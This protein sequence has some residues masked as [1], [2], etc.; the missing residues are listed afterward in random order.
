M[1]PRKR[2]MTPMRLPVRDDI[3]AAM[4]SAESSPELASYFLDRIRLKFGILASKTTQMMAEAPQELQAYF[5]KLS[6]FEKTVIQRFKIHADPWAGQEVTGSYFQNMQSYFGD[7]AIAALK[8][9]GLNKPLVFDVAIN[10]RGQLVRAY[11][12]DRQAVDAKTT[13]CLDVAFNAWLAK[14][15]IVTKESVLYESN[16]KGE[17][18]IDAKGNPIRVSE[19]KIQALKEDLKNHF[20]GHMQGKGIEVA[21]YVHAYPE[22][23]EQVLPAATVTT[24]TTAP[25]VSTAK[26]LTSAEEVSKEKPEEEEIK[27]SVGKVGG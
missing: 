9:S 13:E 8:E 16:Q 24:Q 1:A 3:L 15:G 25:T 10:E 26:P 4:E 5:S 12:V 23:Q 27:P 6:D 19:E 18:Q 17:I 11:S 21:V 7:E 22:V 20:P 14:R 2:R